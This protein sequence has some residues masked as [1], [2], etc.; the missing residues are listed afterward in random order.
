MAKTDAEVITKALR[1][2]GVVGIGDA[3]DG[4]D[5]RTTQPH[6][7]HVL[8]ALDAEHRVGLALVSGA[9]EDRA[10]IPLAKMVAGSVC[11]EYEVP[12]FQ[13]LYNQGLRSLRAI[14]AEESRNPGRSIKTEYF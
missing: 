1:L 14:A 2:I 3:P 5:V 7:A 10:F 6:L 4:D 11:T 13:V 9:I 12:Q 8:S